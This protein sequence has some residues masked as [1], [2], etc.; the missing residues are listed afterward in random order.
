MIKKISKLVACCSIVWLLMFVILPFITST[1]QT[2]EQLANYID[3][4]GIETGN[5][6]YTSVEAVTQAEAGA[7]GAVFFTKHHFAGKEHKNT[8][9]KS[10]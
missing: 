1:S 7:R 2:A 5:F 8:Q 10:D 3:E 6:Y 9:D 4:S